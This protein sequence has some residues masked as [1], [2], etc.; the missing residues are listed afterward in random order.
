MIQHV[1]VLHKLFVALTARGMS[2]RNTHKG[3]GSSHAIPPNPTFI[4]FPRSDG[5]PSNWPTNTTPHIDSE[6][7]VNF[8]RQ[9]SLDES[10]SIK[11]R[12]EVGAALA[13]K[14]NMP[15]ECFLSCT[16][17]RSFISFF[18]QRATMFCKD[19]LRAIRCSITTKAQRIVLVMMPIL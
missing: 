10:L 19:G 16:S 13:S 4:D 12:V 5:D 9:A 14:L 1:V 3:F 11:W 15:R 2:A 17:H 6:G 18:Q 8:M 7:H